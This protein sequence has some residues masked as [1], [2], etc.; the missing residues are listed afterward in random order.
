MAGGD[1][2]TLSP[3]EEVTKQP[4][5]TGEVV[6]KPHADNTNPIPTTK[7]PTY[8]NILKAAI[9]A[10]PDF[11]EPA[12][13]A[14]QFSVSEEQ[15]QT[16]VELKPTK[17]QDGKTSVR[18]KLSDKARYLNSMKYVL[19]GK[20]S[21]GRPPIGL[22]KEFFA[23][24]SIANT[25]GSPLRIDQLNIN[26][27]KLGSASVCVSLDVSKPIL[28]KI[29]VAFEDED[30]EEVVEGF[31]EENAKA[32]E[33][34]PEN[35][36]RPV[37]RRVPIKPRYQAKAKPMKRTTKEWVKTV[38]GGTK[39]EDHG[40]EISNSFKSLEVLVP[41]EEVKEPTESRRPYAGINHNILDAASLPPLSLLS[42][43]SLKT[44]TYKDALEDFVLPLQ[45]KSTPAS[46]TKQGEETT[47]VQSH[48]QTWEGNGE[49]VEGEQEI[50]GKEG[51]IPSHG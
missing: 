2:P 33:S 16:S 48:D 9:H 10:A 46:P 37:F 15:Q 14:E 49:V 1:Q 17:V 36:A 13:T 12:I 29:W 5:P 43:C 41:S 21:H 19:V 8:S 20:F 47:L 7:E 50:N 51:D 23:L 34:I 24:F 35:K 27:V 40:A 30:S 22:L 45:G 3:T 42:G 38:F 11:T 18:F 44:I 31:C 28:D 26:R 6:K 25:I 4:S 32:V 39:K